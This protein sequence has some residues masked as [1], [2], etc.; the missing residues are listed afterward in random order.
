MGSRVVTHPAGS[1]VQRLKMPLIL[2]RRAPCWKLNVENCLAIYAPL[3]SQDMDLPDP[4]RVA[5][6]FTTLHS[7]ATITKY[8]TKMT[9]LFMQATITCKNNNKKKQINFVCVVR[10]AIG[11]NFDCGGYVK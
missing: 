2:S 9:T 8:L 10:I 6:A 3:Q 7:K 11:Q 1:A 4:A 5:T